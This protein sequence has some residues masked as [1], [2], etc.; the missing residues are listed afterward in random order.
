LQIKR[1]ALAAYHRYINVRFFV[2]SPLAKLPNTITAHPGNRSL[3][4]SAR[5]D[6]YTDRM[7]SPL[8]IPMTRGFSL[9]NAIENLFD[10]R[11]L[12]TRTNSRFLSSGRRPSWRPAGSRPIH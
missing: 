10:D 6:S 9:F 11:S 1:L 12:R 2:S 3:R 4:N 8:F 5:P 7:L